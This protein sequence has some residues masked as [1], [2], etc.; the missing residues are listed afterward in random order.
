MILS[1]DL[2]GLITPSSSTM[3]VSLF[4]LIPPVSLSARKLVNCKNPQTLLI[5]WIKPFWV[6]G[7]VFGSLSS[8]EFDFQLLADFVVATSKYNLHMQ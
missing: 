6:F 8:R 1:K 5:S 2:E 7:S 4:T 3:C